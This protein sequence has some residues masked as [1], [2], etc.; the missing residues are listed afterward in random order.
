MQCTHMYNVNIEIHI[1][2]HKWKPRFSIPSQC[3]NKSIYGMWK[4]RLQVELATLTSH[5][6]ELPAT[7]LVQVSWMTTKTN[8]VKVWLKHRLKVDLDHFK[9]TKLGK[10]VKIARSLDTNHVRWESNYQWRPSKNRRKYQ[11]V[12]IRANRK[13]WIT[14]KSIYQIPM[15]MSDLFNVRNSTW[16]SLFLFKNTCICMKVC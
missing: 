13:I 3:Y 6:F 10:D 1:L 4:N 11:E 14:R 7:A 15:S 12:Y 9:W 2:S 5:H 8:V 16:F